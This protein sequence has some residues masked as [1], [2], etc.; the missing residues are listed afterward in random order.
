[1]RSEFG[2]VENGFSK[3]S[4]P[5]LP[6]FALLASGH[7]PAI[8]IRHDAVRSMRKYR[9][10][11]VYGDGLPAEHELKPGFLEN[12]E[13]KKFPLPHNF[14]PKAASL[15]HLLRK[16]RRSAAQ[17]VGTAPINN[18]NGMTAPSQGR[19]RE[20]G[21]AGRVQ[22]FGAEVFGSVFKHDAAG[23]NGRPR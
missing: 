17:G 1:M 3:M 14:L 21:M 23:G 10:R 8:P 6:L 4:Y 16:H 11:D 12:R 9:Q 13:R 22:S 2:D 20:R 15:I 7:S 19:S 18:R 5:H